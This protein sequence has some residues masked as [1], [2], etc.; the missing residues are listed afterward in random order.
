MAG[1]GAEVMVERVDSDNEAAARRWFTAFEPAADDHR[2]VPT[3][4]MF[5]DWYAA[6]HD[7]SWPGAV[8]WVRSRD[9]D[10]VG[11]MVAHTP[12]YD[13]R[14]VLDLGI[15]VAPEHRRH[16]IGAALLDVAQTYAVD[17]GRTTVLAEVVEPLATAQGSS[18]GSRF[19]Q[20]AGFGVGMVE[21]HRIIELP[22]SDERLQALEDHAA[23]RRNGYQLVEFGA[24]CPPEYVDRFC[25]AQSRFLHEAP[26]GDLDVE[27]EVW[28]PERLAEAEVRR[29]RQGR[30][31][32]SVLAIA[33]DGAVA[34]YTQLV[35]P[36]TDDGRVAQADTLVLPDHRGHRLGLAMKLRNLRR[37][38]EHWPDR[39]YV[40]TWNAE[41][42]AAML[43]VN[44]ALG[45]T[46]RERMIEYQRTDGQ[47]ATG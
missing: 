6:L 15:R 20:A 35:V 18:A 19:A 39:T 44:A 10:V 24:R 31:S 14:H 4:M 32:L 36:P 17:H 43:A 41:G 1:A 45:A 28:T 37:L 34:G 13:N 8:F 47:R 26:L 16:G 21:N 25:A 46:A 2:A 9:D 38:Q 30:D 22:V 40:G 7:P 12:A 11:T 23:A 33:P 27:P 42:N 29:V 5:D 3:H